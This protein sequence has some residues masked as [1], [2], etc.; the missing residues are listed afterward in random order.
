MAV[1]LA[2]VSLVAAGVALLI[3]V[4]NHFDRNRPFVGVKSL[5]AYP[6]SEGH[7]K[8][9]NIMVENMGLMPA[10]GVT[11]RVTDSGGM[12]NSLGK[13]DLPPLAKR[14]RPG[15]HQCGAAR[16]EELSCPS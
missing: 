7:T 6:H 16:Q 3:S 10:V 1:S 14:A 8:R 9:L 15:A 12:I 13:A 11:I 4:M 5:N 2:I